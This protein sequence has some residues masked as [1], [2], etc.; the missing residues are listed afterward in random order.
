MKQTNRTIKKQRA[1]RNSAAGA[2]FYALF[3]HCRTPVP[4]S[5]LGRERRFSRMEPIDGAVAALRHHGEQDK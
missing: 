5:L 4:A 1:C 2:L 3:A